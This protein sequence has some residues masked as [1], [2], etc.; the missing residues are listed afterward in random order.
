MSKNLLADWLRERLRERGISQRKLSIDTGIATGTI[1]AIMHGHIPRAGTV[2]TLARYFGVET[3]TLLEIAGIAEFSDVPTDLP[4]ELRDLVRRLYRLDDRERDAILNQMRGLLDLLEGR[5][6]ES[7]TPL[8]PP[9][10]A[11]AESTGSAASLAVE[12]SG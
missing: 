3:S 1:S 10:S 6:R 5:F 4:V 8:P 12:R 2:T 7:E 9:A 11:G